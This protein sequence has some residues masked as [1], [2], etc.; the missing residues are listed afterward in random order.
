LRGQSVRR[1]STLR[2]S[3]RNESSD[4]SDWFVPDGFSLNDQRRRAVTSA[5]KPPR[6]TSLGAQLGRDKRGIRH[7]PQTVITA[8]SFHITADEIAETLIFRAQISFQL[9]A[10][11]TIYRRLTRWHQSDLC[12]GGF[13]IVQH[14]HRANSDCRRGCIP[15]RQRKS[16]RKKIL[17]LA[18]PHRG[19]I[20]DARVTNTSRQLQGFS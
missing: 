15:K 18:L 16:P 14:H 20:C 3:H 6:A 11:T 5:I 8:S 7:E 1:F 9:A 13:R 12:S 10:G 2:A 17:R 19:R 4:R